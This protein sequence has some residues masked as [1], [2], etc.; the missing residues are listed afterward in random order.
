MNGTN[1]P[2][3]DTVMRQYAETWLDPME[4]LLRHNAYFPATCLACV[5]IDHLGSARQKERG[6]RHERDYIDFLRSLEKYGLP[7]DYDLKKRIYS[8][9][10][11]GLVHAGRT[12]DHQKER[13]VADRSCLSHE[14]FVPTVVAENDDFVLSV[15]WFCRAVRGMWN[16]LLQNTNERVQIQVSKRLKRYIV[17]AD[18][19]TGVTQNQ[20]A[21]GFGLNFSDD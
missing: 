18:S 15:P 10:R 5:I 12:D 2:E 9:V 16:D 7:E 20:P 21:T 14:D 17:E 11:N 6:A 13:E 1:N 8:T 3:F 4:C 19:R